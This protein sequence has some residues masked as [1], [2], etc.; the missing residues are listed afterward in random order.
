MMKFN[1]LSMDYSTNH[2]SYINPIV[3]L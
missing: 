2:T 1:I 3:M